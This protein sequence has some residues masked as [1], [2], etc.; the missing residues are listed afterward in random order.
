MIASC[1]TRISHLFIYLFINCSAHVNYLQ[2]LNNKTYTLFQD[3]M[4]T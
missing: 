4:Y 2:G 1:N 3:S